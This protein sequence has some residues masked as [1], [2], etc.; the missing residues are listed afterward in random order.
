MNGNAVSP[1]VTATVSMTR[2]LTFRTDPEAQTYLPKM[3][4]VTE[5]ASLQVVTFLSF[6]LQKGRLT[7]VKDLL[8]TPA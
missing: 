4:S 8:L 3:P 7:V 1:K 6:F 2:F 5:A